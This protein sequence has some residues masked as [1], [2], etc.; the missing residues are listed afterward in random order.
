MGK[1][2]HLESPQCLN[3]SMSTP[4]SLNPASMPET[5]QCP[6]SNA[7]PQRLN[8]SMPETS[9]ATPQRL[10]APMPQCLNASMPEIAQSPKNRLNA[11]N[12]QSLKRPNHLESA[13]ISAPKSST[14]EIRRNEIEIQKKPTTHNFFLWIA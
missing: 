14:Q 5:P 8:A 11:R 7:T 2:N 10:N 9:N 6:K 4:E 12:I 13:N 3:A 1:S